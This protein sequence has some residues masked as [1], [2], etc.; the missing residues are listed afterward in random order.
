MNLLTVQNLIIKR[1]GVT[2]LEINE[3]NILQGRIHALIGPN[4]A[5][6]STLLLTMAGLLKPDLGNIIDK[7]LL[8]VVGSIGNGVLCVK[9][10]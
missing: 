2:V 1:S 8:F 7:N 4:G 5:G 3:L 6:K 9:K 10:I